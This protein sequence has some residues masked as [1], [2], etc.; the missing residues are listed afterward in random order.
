MAKPSTTL[1][2]A[3]LIV[4]AMM[5]PGRTGAIEVKK[6]L[7][8]GGGPTAGGGANAG[9]AG[10]PA[11]PNP[12]SAAQ[13]QSLQ[14]AVASDSDQSV[15]EES[16]KKAQG[17]PYVDLDHAKFSY[18]PAGGNVTA[19]LTAD[20]CKGKKGGPSAKCSPTG[21]QKSLVFKYKLQGSKVAASEPPKWEDA[22]A[23]TETAKTK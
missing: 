11:A 8:S 7:Y 22:K 12:L 5:A 6:S 1:A 20:E 9:P 2:V 23:E 4:A 10:G 16:E 15:G 21:N 17:Q 18:I 14:D 3:G 19:K 13:K